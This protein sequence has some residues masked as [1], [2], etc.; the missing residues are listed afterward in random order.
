MDNTELTLLIER[1]IRDAV[2]K[3]VSEINNDQALFPTRTAK[4]VASL[5][6]VSAHT[7]HAWHKAGFLEGRYQILSGYAVRLIFTN[8]ALCKFFDANFP[9]SADIFASDFHPKSS[10]AQ[11]VKKMLSMKKIFSRRRKVVNR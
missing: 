1:T 7:V 4:Q 11:R 9:S 10:K 3:Y 6:N 5:F 8:R 2:K